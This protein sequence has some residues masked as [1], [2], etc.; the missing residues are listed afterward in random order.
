MTCCFICC[1]ILAC[2]RVLRAVLEGWDVAAG[3]RKI[4]YEERNILRCLRNNIGMI[5][6]LG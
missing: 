3:G 5:K 2:L 4:V 6:S 1:E